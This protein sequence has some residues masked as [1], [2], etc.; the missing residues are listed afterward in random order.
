[1][2]ASALEASSLLVGLSSEEVK[3]LAAVGQTR[4]YGTGEVIVQEGTASDCL[5][6]L[7][8][9]IVAVERV[10]GERRVELAALTEVGDFFGEM[11]LIDILPRSAA[12]DAGVNAG[13]TTDID[14]QPRP[15]DGLYDIGAD[16]L[17]DSLY[18]P[19]V[20]RDY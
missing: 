10:D 8:S 12:V 16:E 9:G 6:I 14:G 3:A 15:R 18:L 11:S 19:L 13:V 7:T 20:A 2:S 5:Y 1:M 17:N 4:R